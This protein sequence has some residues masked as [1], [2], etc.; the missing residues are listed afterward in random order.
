MLTRLVCMR[1]QPDKVDEFLRL[2]AAARA[3][4]AA[5]PGCCG[6]LL[7]REAEDPAAFATWS[8]WTDAAALEA[9][10]T[11]VFFRG[12]WPEVKALFR[13]PA[14]AASFAAVDGALFDAEVT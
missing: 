9:Y 14:E 13:T 5:Q 8:Q 6:V 7:L 1:F 12:F 11:S 4:I 2:Y 3:T 10:R